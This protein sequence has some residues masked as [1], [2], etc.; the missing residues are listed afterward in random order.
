MG[1]LGHRFSSVCLVAALALGT[2]A[3]CGGA[4]STPLDKPPTGPSESGDDATSQGS[5]DAG[6]SSSSGGGR[7]A[8]LP[9]DTGVGDTTSDGA[10]DSAS[11]D[12][13]SVSVIEAGP[14]DA[15]FCGVCS[16]GNRCCM[17]PGTLSY[18]QCYSELCGPC[19]F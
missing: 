12:A 7:D 3:A 19:C 18:G 13:D 10:D 15:G 11:D 8:T 6:G 9:E 4:A 1:A 14:P 16:V 5:Q 17:V 2:W